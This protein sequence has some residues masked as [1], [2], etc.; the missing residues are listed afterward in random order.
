[1]SKYTELKF[2][3]QKEVDAFPFGFA[4]NESQFKEMMEKW[5]L[6]PDDTDKIYSIGGGG[7]VRKSDADA[8]HKMFERHE[9]ERKMARKHGDDYLFEMFNYEL[10]NHEYNYTGDLTDTLEAL[11]LTMDEIN[12]DPRMADALKRAIAAQED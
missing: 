4:F 11:G 6:T 9:L 5:G 10:A 2:K 8:M 12:A 7:Y 1:M 3:H